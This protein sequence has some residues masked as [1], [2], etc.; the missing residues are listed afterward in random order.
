M[1][2]DLHWDIKGVSEE[3]E[4]LSSYCMNLKGCPH[5]KTQPPSAG[6]TEVAQVQTLL[7]LRG[8][9]IW[10]YKYGALHSVFK[11]HC[12]HTMGLLPIIPALKSESS[13]RTA[14][15]TQEVK[16]HPELQ[17]KIIFQWNF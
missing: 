15:A 17:N 14:W 11:N 10:P 9:L 16:G 13:E 2:G 1:K 3:G 8:A 6:R 4:L 5:P 7:S 12:E